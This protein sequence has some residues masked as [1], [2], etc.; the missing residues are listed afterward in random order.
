MPKKIGTSNFAPRVIITDFELLAHNITTDDV[1]TFQEC[2]EARK[3]QDHHYGA[4]WF[5]TAIIQKNRK[6]SIWKH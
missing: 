6:T 1:L 3:G 5:E 2:R 4:Q